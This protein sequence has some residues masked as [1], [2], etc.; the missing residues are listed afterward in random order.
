MANSVR[1]ERHNTD[2]HGLPL[3]RAAEHIDAVQIG[4]ERWAH[5]AAETSSWWVVSA[6]ELESLCDYLDDETI[7]GDAYSLWCADTDA[8]EKPIGWEP[9]EASP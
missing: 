5:Y 9:V 8:R 2:G 3:A 6:D 1:V 4:A 7:R